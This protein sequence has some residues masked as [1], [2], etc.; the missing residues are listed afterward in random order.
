MKR[1]PPRPNHFDTDRQTAKASS[2]LPPKKP[3][4]QPLE[5]ENLKMAFNQRFPSAPEKAGR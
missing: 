2:N 4:F 1:L 5:I 3:R